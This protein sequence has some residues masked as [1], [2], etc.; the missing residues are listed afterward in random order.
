MLDRIML[1]PEQEDLLARLVEA[2]R[3]VPH[4]QRR[5]FIA[6][7]PMAEI[8]HTI[9]HQG[10][11]EGQTQALLSDIEILRN[12]GLIAMS[13]GDGSSVSFYVLPPGNTYY[14]HVKQRGNAPVQV[15]ES[16]ILAYLN[17]DAFKQRYPEALKKLSNATDL[18]WPADSDQQLTTIGHL[19]REAMQAFATV[20]VERYQLPGTP[21]NKAS[22]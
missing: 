19:C 5:S 1:E 14:Q 21:E 16:T 22:T 17:A 13:G 3:S 18:L 4:D 8:L 12:N 2:S 15:I 11:P 7:R 9:Y 6:Y 20:L 10:L